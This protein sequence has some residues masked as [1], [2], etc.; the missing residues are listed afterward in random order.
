MSK[1]SVPASDH[2][3][4]TSNV[5]LMSVAVQKLRP[6]RTTGRTPEGPREDKTIP[7]KIEGGA[8]IP[9]PRGSPFKTRVWCSR[10]I[11]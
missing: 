10:E 5:G 6:S 1:L 11:G 7:I 2:R 8:N 9:N 3:S 4:D